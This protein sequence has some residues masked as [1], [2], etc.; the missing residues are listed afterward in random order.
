MEFRLISTEFFN[1]FSNGEL[2]DQNLNVLTT[3]LAGNITDKMRTRQ[4]VAVSWTA[5]SDT[6]NRFIVNGNT[7]TQNGGNFINLG[8]SFGDVISVRICF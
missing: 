5:E 7:L 8:F 6:V 1:Q 4:T 2:L 3:N